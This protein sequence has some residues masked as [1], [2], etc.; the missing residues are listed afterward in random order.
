MSLAERSVRAVGWNALSNSARVVIL[1][2]RSVLLA[3]WLPVETFGVY[4]GANAVVALAGIVATFGMGAAFLHRC[5]ETEDEEHT[6][7]V[8]FTLQLILTL[9]WTG[10]MLLGALLF[11]DGE[12]QLALLLMTV[13]TAGTQL[14][15]TPRLILVRRVVHRRLALLDFLNAALTTAVAV[16]LAWGGIQLWALLATDVVAVI[17]ALSMLYLWR[18]VWR[19]RLAWD[20]QVIRY[21]LRFGSR[22]FAAVALQR[23]LDKVDDLWT[24]LFL[25]TNAMG[26][27]SRAYTFAT[28][29]RTILAL[30][31]N[32]VADGTYAELKGQRRR[33][34]QAF[35]R[36]NALLVRTGFFLAGVLALV[37]PEFI[38]LLLGAKWLPMLDA[39]R[40]MLVYTLLDPIKITVA[41]VITASGT[42][43]RVIRVRFVQLVILFIGL[44]TLGPAFGITGVAVAVDLMLVVGI[45][46]LLMEARRFVDFSWFRLFAVPTL[47]LA[48]GLLS[49]RL[50]I[51]LPGVLQ[52][53]WSS[54]GVKMAAFLVLY[55]GILLGL[56]RENV[57]VLVRILM[58]LRRS[59]EG[60]LAV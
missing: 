19:P 44:V 18:P 22:S 8:H 37:A 14:T 49:G 7:A 38:R 2:G 32:A 28:Y 54:G 35:F 40:L 55:V 27:Y 41:S 36:A 5:A 34:S 12:T 6:A 58:T 13:T 24:R 1:F 15:H 59:G 51:M 16:G 10:L 20:R 9:A 31:V 30:P 17:L 48:V 23:A 29:P 33:L 4:A 21:L 39:F 11:T 56:E 45:L 52:S 50:A 43:E 60:D 53:D 25:G 26:L 42:P 46:L 57:R 47:A 3:R